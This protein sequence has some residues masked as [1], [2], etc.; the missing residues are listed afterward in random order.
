MYHLKVTIALYYIMIFVLAVKID[1]L[2]LENKP[3]VT[4]KGV[5]SHISVADVQNVLDYVSE[6]LKIE[7]QLLRNEEKSF[8]VHLKLKNEGSRTIEPCC[9]TIFFYH[10]NALDAVN[11]HKKKTPYA[12]RYFRNDTVRNPLYP[13]SDFEVRHINGNSYRLDMTKE[14][15]GLLPGEEMTIVLTGFRWIVSRSTIIPNWYVASSIP[16]SQ[17]RL[18]HSTA[19]DDLGFVA[20]FD[21]REKTSRSA[22]DSLRPLSPPQR[23]EKFR[24][25]DIHDSLDDILPTPSLVKRP[26]VPKELKVESEIFKIYYSRGLKNEATYLK[27]KEFFISEI[28]AEINLLYY[29]I[30][31]WVLSD[32]W[33]CFLMFK[34]K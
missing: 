3:T 25:K 13:S 29:C 7:Y 17:P 22:N 20:P 8:L 4:P 16:S 21:S 30:S 34:L 27:G 18:I 19:G 12:S 28:S 32:F 9:F 15:K 10:F 26:A 14:F 31:L 24:I 2:T 11:L 33:S 23:F 6:H 1:L 5:V